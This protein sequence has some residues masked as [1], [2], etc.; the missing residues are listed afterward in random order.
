MA[1]SVDSAS[2]T[3]HEGAVP[4]APTCLDRHAALGIQTMRRSISCRCILPVLLRGSTAASTTWNS[5]GT[6]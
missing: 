1:V 2:T 6:L 3:L 5:R 4:A